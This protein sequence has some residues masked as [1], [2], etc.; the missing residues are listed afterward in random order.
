V[1]V[2]LP[3]RR[4]ARHVEAAPEAPG[5][6][7]LATGELP[8]DVQRAWDRVEKAAERLAR[9]LSAELRCDPDFMGFRTTARRCG[10]A[11]VDVLTNLDRW[12]Q[13]TTGLASPS[14]PE[15]RFVR[16]FIDEVAGDSGLL[17]DALARR[18][19]RRTAERLL[20]KCPAV[21]DAVLSGETPDVV[22][23]DE[24]FCE[25]YRLFFADLVEELFRAVIFAKLVT[26]TPV[27]PLVDPADLASRAAARVVTRVFSPCAER[28]RDPSKT[29]TAIARD[30]A[31]DIVERPL[32]PAEEAT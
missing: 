21:R 4:S 11:L 28:K 12:S 25:L 24:V 26:V 17:V 8:R 16:W 5:E 15:D 18:A 2:T 1:K 13:S 22:L 29:L 10:H 14:D 9:A 31:D 32:G 30:M 7:A 23:A 3:T 19:A 27:L 20:E 6:R